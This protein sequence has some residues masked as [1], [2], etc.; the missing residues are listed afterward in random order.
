M[1]CKFFIKILELNNTGKQTPLLDITLK[2]SEALA[3]YSIQW[4]FLWWFWCYQ[5]TSTPWRWGRK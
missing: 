1:P 4:N 2:S 5:S 3:G